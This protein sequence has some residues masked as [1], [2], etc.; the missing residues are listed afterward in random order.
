[1]L[2]EGP[3]T[4]FVRL[5]L[6]MKYESIEDYQK[7]LSR[8]AALPVQISQI[9]DLMKKGIKEELTFN[10]V[11][12]VTVPD[13]LAV[14]DQSDL[15]TKRP[16]DCVFYKPFL[17][18]PDSISSKKKSLQREAVE[19]ISSNVMPA[20]KTLK[21]FL[22]KEYIK[23]ARSLPSISTLPGGS[24]FYQLCLD[25]HLGFRLLPKDV[26]EMGLNEVKRISG[27]IEKVMLF[28]GYTNV[29]IKDFTEL[30][31]SDSRFFF[32]KPAELLEAY[33]DLIFNKICPKLKKLFKSIPEDEL[34]I[35]PSPSVEDDAP[36]GFYY[37]GTPD[38]VRPAVFY[39]NKDV[40][41]V[42]KYEMMS[43]ALHEALPGHHL[44][45]C[46]NFSVKNFPE[47]RKYVEDRKY[48]EIPSRFPL[49]T[50]YAEGWGLY[51]E[52]LGSELGLY[53]DKYDYFG[54]L[55]QELFRAARLVVD[56]G[57]HAFN[58]SQDQAVA[59]MIENTASSKRVI[60]NEVKRYITW[61]G[62]ACAYK[63]GE[64]KI[65]SLRKMAENQ[66]GSNFNIQDFHEVLLNNYGPLDVLEKKVL[67]YVDDKKDV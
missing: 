59:Y 28:L 15:L 52:F 64:M 6:A 22:E 51:S 9:I 37:A 8:F 55:S 62:Q 21:E 25:F 16:E 14:L 32:E 30:L 56:T 5:I 29:S 26:H 38:G 47:F 35:E 39:F 17:S 44:Q 27:E 13:Q 20:F 60:E 19:S 12:V 2:K 66:L 43:L 40:K 23:K 34:S 46:F 58:W 45:Q 3:Q 61:P 63:I 10:A 4:E 49:H 48:S 31:R 57:I 18:V 33:K 11:S 67:E 7:L 1:M 54:Y 41:S 50:A 42:P 65:K 24:T 53:E 36:I